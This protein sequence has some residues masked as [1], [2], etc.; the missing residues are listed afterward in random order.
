[1]Y[2]NVSAEGVAGSEGLGCSTIKVVLGSV[3]SIL[4]VVVRFFASSFAQDERKEKVMGHRFGFRWF[5]A[6]IFEF[7]FAIGTNIIAT[8]LLPSPH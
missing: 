7:V 3:A 5:V 8:T 4:L 2:G 6:S 1:M